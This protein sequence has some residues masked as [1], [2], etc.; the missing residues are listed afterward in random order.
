MSAL[1]TVACLAA[2][3]HG[4]QHFLYPNV[5]APAAD[6]PDQLLDSLDLETPQVGSS[7]SAGDYGLGRFESPSARLG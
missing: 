2:F 4:Q 7:G 5:P 1:A 6:E 3:E